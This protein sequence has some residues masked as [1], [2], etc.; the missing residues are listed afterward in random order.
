VI[1]FSATRKKV[2][3]KTTASLDT[4]V[5][6]VL[7]TDETTPLQLGVDPADTLYKVT[8]EVVK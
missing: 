1:V 5:E 2:Q 7:I 8:I 3:A 6:L 4:E